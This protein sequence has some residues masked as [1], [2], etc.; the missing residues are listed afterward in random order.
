MFPC[1]SPMQ[2][3]W[4]HS[5][6]FRRLCLTLLRSWLLIV[7]TEVQLRQLFQVIPKK[8]KLSNPDLSC[9]LPTV[10]A[11]PFASYLQSY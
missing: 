1:L 8:K 7:P 11:K 2:L 3:K 9:L 4:C 5:K 6:A 10:R